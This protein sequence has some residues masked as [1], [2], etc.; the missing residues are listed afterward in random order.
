MPPTEESYTTVSERKKQM[1]TSLRNTEW[2]QIEVKT[3]SV[4]KNFLEEEH[5][6]C[7]AEIC[8][9]QVFPALTETKSSRRMGKP[10]RVMVAETFDLSSVLRPHS[11][12]RSH[13][14]PHNIFWLHT[15]HVPPHTHTL[16]LIEEKILKHLIKFCLK[17]T[18]F[19]FESLLFGCY[20][21]F[22]IWE[23][24]Q[25]FSHL[26]IFIHQMS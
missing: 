10:V 14:L 8:V 7:N 19:G 12:K 2:I 17:D 3:I 18:G 20:W 1:E 9:K 22:N 15:W 4:F 5:A 25:I 11:G 26:H 21:S 16:N 6:L 24:E 23:T 13:K